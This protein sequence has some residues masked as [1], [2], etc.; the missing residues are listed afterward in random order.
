[1][2][3]FLSLKFVDIGPRPGAIEPPRITGDDDPE[4]FFPPLDASG[5]IF[6][7]L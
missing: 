6:K 7:D 1:M 4:R 5:L 3:D 2:F